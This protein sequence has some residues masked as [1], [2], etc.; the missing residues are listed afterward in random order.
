MEINDFCVCS[1]I[2]PTMF[3]G[4]GHGGGNRQGGG[5][6]W[7]REGQYAGFMSHKCVTFLLAEKLLLVVSVRPVLQLLQNS[8]G[9]GCACWGSSLK[10]G[11]PCLAASLS[12]LAGGDLEGRDMK[13]Q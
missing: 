9:V 13:A 7:I 6:A 8:L 3:S 1:E 12:P 4:T 11:S 10:F 2:F 5:G